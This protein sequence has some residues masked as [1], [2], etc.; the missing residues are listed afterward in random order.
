MSP[1]AKATDKSITEM[2]SYILNASFPLIN[3]LGSVLLPP[4][5]QQSLAASSMATHQL[6]FVNGVSGIGCFLLVPLLF[7][8]S[9]EWENA[10]L[11][12]FDCG[13]QSK[14]FLNH[15]PQSLS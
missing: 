8:G 1:V 3:M 5:M 2:Q 12:Y 7:T 13:Y 6:T 4:R 9:S 11:D 14:V 10:I 15:H